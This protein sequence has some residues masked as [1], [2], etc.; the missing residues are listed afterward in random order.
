MKLKEIISISGKPGLYRIVNF[1]KMPYIVEE[2]TTG[3]KVPIFGRE[4]VSS[5][6]EIALYTEEGDLPLGQV[7]QCIHEAYGDTI[8]EE[9]EVTQ[10]HE[11]LRAFMDKVL[12][13]YDQERVHDSDIRKLVKWYIIL[14]K[15]GM[16][17]FVE[18]E[19][20]NSNE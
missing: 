3:R 20:N 16:V 8:P 10:S 2:L 7:F 12:P 9:K 13:S 1:A 4:K 18:E 14:R 11:T 5:L 6:A 19:E 17:L 15:K